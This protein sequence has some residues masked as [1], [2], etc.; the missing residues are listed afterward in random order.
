M[1]KRNRAPEVITYLIFKYDIKI[2]RFVFYYI[3]NYCQD[4]S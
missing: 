2:S 3:A 1:L 4:K